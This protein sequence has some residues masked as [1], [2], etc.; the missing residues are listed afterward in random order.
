MKID[1]GEAVRQVADQSRSRARGHLA[2]PT[3]SEDAI[4][5][6]SSPAARK[7]RRSEQREGRVSE[8][9]APGRARL[10]RRS[11]CGGSSGTPHGAQS[12]ASADGGNHA[13]DQRMEME[14]LVRVAVIEREAGR[15]KGLELRGDFCGELAARPRLTAIDGAE[16]AMS[17]RKSPLPSDE[18]GHGGGGR[19]PAGRP[20]APHA[21]R[22]ASEGMRRARATASAA[23][24]AATIRLAAVRIP[25]R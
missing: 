5:D 21:A 24:G 6:A 17:E 3:Q 11:T 2:R 13:G 20:P 18:M 15:A 22:R 25:P 12:E 23:A 1:F 16:A 7:R 9:R 10:D 4:G 8:G 19:A 14:M